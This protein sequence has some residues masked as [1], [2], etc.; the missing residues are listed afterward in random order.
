MESFTHL[1]L[2]PLL[3]LYSKHTPF[4]ISSLSIR[5]VTTPQSITLN[6]GHRGLEESQN[7]DKH[8]RKLEM[9]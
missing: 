9:K 8:W 5:N 3:C 4:S 7:I 2:L 1:Y 6:R